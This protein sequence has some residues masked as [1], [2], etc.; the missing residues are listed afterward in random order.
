MHWTQLA[1]T[2]FSFASYDWEIMDL[3]SWQHPV[4]FAVTRDSDSGELGGFHWNSALENWIETAEEA[5]LES[6]EPVFGVLGTDLANPVSEGTALEL[7][8]EA[9]FSLGDF[10]LEIWTQS[11]A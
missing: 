11:L 5:F 4:C 9:Q 1:E 2:E 6:E 8:L 10:D 3:R 7:L